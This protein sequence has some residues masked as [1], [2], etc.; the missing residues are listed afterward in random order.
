MAKLKRLNLDEVKIVVAETLSAAEA[1]RKLNMSTQGSATRFRKFLDDNKI[2]YSHWTGQLWSKGKTSLEDNRIK[3]T[4][5]T[6]EDIFCEDSSANAT[7]VKS[8]IIKKE[9][10]PYKCSVCN[11]NPVWNGKELKLQMDHINGNKRDQ[12]LE[13]LRMICPN[14]HSQTETFGSKNKLKGFPSEERIISVLKNTNSI[15]E[16][17][18]ELGINKINFKKL[19]TIIEDN[20]IVQPVKEKKI[21]SCINCNQKYDS[22]S[23]KFCSRNC[24]IE[25]SNNPTNWEHGNINTYEYRKCRCDLCKKA[26]TEYKRK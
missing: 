7:Y 15:T 9:L 16:A 26:N 4:A 1:C 25:F 18:R 11:M 3:S 14:C 20:N 10:L 2:D 12:R 5:N 21:K 13:N 23:Q 24:V 6:Y 8:L 22:K 17:I 19:K